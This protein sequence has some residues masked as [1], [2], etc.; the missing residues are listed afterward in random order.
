MTGLMWFA[1]RTYTGLSQYPVFKVQAA[2]DMVLVLRFHPPH[3]AVL[4]SA[5]RRKIT[6]SP[7]PCQQLLGTFS[8][9]VAE[10]VPGP[11]HETKMR[12][13]I[14]PRD[15]YT[16]QIATSCMWHIHV[17]VILS[18]RLVFN[19]RSGLKS[20]LRRAGAVLYHRIYSACKGFARMAARQF[21]I[22]A[23]GRADRV[24]AL[25]GPQ[26]CVGRAKRRL[27]T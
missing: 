14:G 6:H 5:A 10:S 13:S 23:V 2:A 4:C 9:L 12:L 3:A 7:W 15:A 11:S 1:L 24:P 18:V 19:S 20:R 21:R 22:A 17:Y 16:Q 8:R 26:A 27:P 25:F